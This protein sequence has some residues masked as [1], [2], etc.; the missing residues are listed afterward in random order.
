[1][2]LSVFL[3]GAA[4]L[5][6]L[7]LG[8]VVLLKAPDKKPN[9]LFS[10]LLF[11]FFLWSAAELNLI[12]NGIS[13][14]RI[15]FLF[16]PGILLAY[17]FCIFSAI[18]PEY[19]KDASIIKSKRN[20]FLYFLPALFLLYQ[21]ISGNLIEDY[22]S[23]ANGFTLSFGSMEFAAKG[24][25]IGY[26]MLSLSTLS[27]SR[28]EAKTEVQVKRLRYTFT[29]M[30][31]PIAAGSL[32]VAFS[33]WFVGGT[34]AYSFG[35]FPTL[36]IIMGAVLSYTMLKY[37]LLEIDIIFS[38]GLVYTLLSVILAGSM[39]ILQEVMQELL[40]LPG[41]WSKFITVLMVAAFF[42][43]LKDFL[44]SVVDRFFGRHSFDSAKVM[45]HVL[46][47]MRQTPD[48]DKL[49]TKLLLE[50]KLV[51]EFES[52]VIVINDG[53]QISH[54]DN[55][56]PE[57][58]RI[59]F[60]GLDTEINNLDEICN[61]YAS[62]NNAEL[63]QKATEL[64]EEGF[65]H[66]FLFANDQKNYGALLLSPKTSKLPYAEIELNLVSS[67]SH[68]IP[69]I[70]ENLQMIDKLLKQERGLQEVKW[71]R[72]MLRSISASNSARSFGDLEIATF[73]SLAEEI[74]GDM[75]DMHR[76][77]QNLFLGVYDAFHHGIHAVLTLNIIFTVFRSCIEPKE[78]FVQA[79]KILRLFLEQNLCSA[80]TLTFERNGK[81]CLYNLG[82]PSP[83]IIK[84]GQV[85]RLITQQ[86]R[87]IG[88]ETEPKYESAE[89]NIAENELLIIS[90][91][92]LY[93]AFDKLKGFS[94]ESFLT[95]KT[96]ESPLECRQ[97]II[98]ALS[99]NERLDFE[100]DITFVIAG[101][102]HDKQT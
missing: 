85:T 29:A 67:I 10:L 78:K 28:K 98:E 93:K 75:I 1:M 73:T 5:I 52:A 76:S 45:R 21:L 37:N 72:K 58:D 48:T 33:R 88:L 61:F 14:T 68:E 30:L 27:H 70:I 38:I 77:E 100:D 24:V 34:T 86:T 19:Q 84:N 53:A 81:Y 64:K 82:N 22:G 94:L 46:S 18:Y 92:G 39:E 32:F 3:C 41:N 23:I 63:T 16:I 4:L 13:E 71:A 59:V 35:V 90:T 51:L 44:D 17:F 69:H 87:P 65:R 74:K 11:L 36:G 9:R 43:P 25:I 101:K 49:F 31:L 42:S 83:L 95:D 2:T 96:F 47:E 97:E 99:N 102:K 57:I 56:R 8:T 15:I 89:V 50:L 7:V 60:T 66:C 40:E 62:E 12:Y 54:P 55:L 80:V 79:N 26:L 6:Q 20:L 91:N